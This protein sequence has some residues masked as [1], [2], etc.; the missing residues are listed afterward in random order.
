MCAAPGGKAFQLISLGAIRDIV[1]K[2][3]FKKG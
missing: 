2:N 3:K 1:E